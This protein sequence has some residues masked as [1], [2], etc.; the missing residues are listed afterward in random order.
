[1]PTLTR[2]IVSSA[3]NPA[4]AT[5]EAPT[6]HADPIVAKTCAGRLR[7]SD[8]RIISTDGTW[9]PAWTGSG[10]PSPGLVQLAGLA[11]RCIVAGPAGVRHWRTWPVVEIAVGGG[12]RPAIEDDAQ[13]ARIHTPQ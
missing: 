2:N 9:G 6:M 3:A 7:L 1:M 12:H 8:A 13:K 10:N 11:F 5:T 4:A